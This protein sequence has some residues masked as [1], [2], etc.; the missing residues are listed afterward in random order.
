[1]GTA[2]ATLI[3]ESRMPTLRC[4]AIPKPFET[5]AISSVLQKRPFDHR[6]TPQSH[7]DEWRD[8]PLSELA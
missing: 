2:R 5:M 1:M 4:A 6:Q 3:V 7:D 8:N